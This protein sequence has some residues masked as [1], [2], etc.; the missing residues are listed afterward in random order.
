MSPP[1]N[2]FR[3]WVGRTP[4]LHLC[5]HQSQDS[6]VKLSSGLEK[7]S[8]AGALT[9]AKSEAPPKAAQAAIGI[10]NTAP[11]YESRDASLSTMVVEAAL[12][13]AMAMGLTMLLLRLRTPK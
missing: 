13:G 2:R 7:K 10:D 1:T 8:G 9:R 4:L 6:F 12:M 3:S 11:G 5:G